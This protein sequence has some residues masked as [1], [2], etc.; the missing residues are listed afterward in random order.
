[1]TERGNPIRYHS[2]TNPSL[3]IL[4]DPMPKGVNKTEE[5]PELG[6]HFARRLRIIGVLKGVLMY[7]KEVKRRHDALLSAVWHT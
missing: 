5:T 2:R 4:I 3:S 6:P 7:G 1:V